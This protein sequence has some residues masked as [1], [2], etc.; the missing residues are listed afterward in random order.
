MLGPPSQNSTANAV[1]ISGSDVFVGGVVYDSTFNS[2]A[3]LWKNGVAQTLT[4]LPRYGS[5][6]G[7]AVSGA[8]VYAVGSSTDSTNGYATVWK[9]GVAT[10][11][12][13]KGLIGPDGKISSY[14]GFG[15]AILV[16]GSDV[17]VVGNDLVNINT[18]HANATGGVAAL[19]KNGVETLLGGT[20]F[21]DAY[22][23]ALAGTDLYV[24][25]NA[26]LT[27]GSSTQSAVYWKNGG[28]VKLADT[29]SNGNAILVS[30]NDVY[31]GGVTG[32]ETSQSKATLW[33]NA[34][35]S[36]LSAGSQRSGVNSLAMLRGDVYAAGALSTTGA[37]YWVNGNPVVVGPAGSG[38]NA[39]TFV[40][41]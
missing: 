35:P 22:G 12:P 4:S 2:Q 17:Y 11:L 14:G 30:G 34:I 36:D 28:L 39:I 27:A 7:L 19:W 21:S 15:R 18:S 20:Y 31:V 41:H 9:N 25:G 6:T 5:V 10:Q 3:V 32:F 13:S 40:T 24:T 8:D 1:A 29:S 37:N 23:L 26:S 16:D 38:W 33:K